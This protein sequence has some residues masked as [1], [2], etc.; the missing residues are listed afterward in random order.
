MSL[1]TIGVNTTEDLASASASTTT[2]TTALDKDAFLLL[3]TTQLQNQDPTEPVSNQEFV[4]Q[5]AQFS[6]LEEM[7]TV[8]GQLDSLYL[9]NVSMNNASMA[10]LLGKEVVARS[11][12]FHHV[13][14]SEEIHFDAASATTSTTLTITDA[15]G[16]VVFSGDIGA[17]GA[18]EGSYTWDGKDQDGQLVADGDYT[19]TLSATDVNGDEVAVESLIQGTVD[20]MSFDTGSAMP[21][22]NGVDITMGD[23]VR[24]VEA[25]S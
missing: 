9:V 20:E 8:S 2:G 10:N 6:Q 21:S 19:F 24:L 12:T 5:L 14:G 23:I 11:D 22:V 7:Q 18:G 25:D 15:D 1:S 16:S 3:L 4:A 13:S 17:E